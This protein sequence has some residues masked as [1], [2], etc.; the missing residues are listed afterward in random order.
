MTS[1]QSRAVDTVEYNMPAKQGYGNAKMKKL[2]KVQTKKGKKGKKKS[3][4]L[5]YDEELGAVVGRKKHKR[6]EEGPTDEP[7]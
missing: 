1:A 2:T 7:W 3:V 4:E 6:G 5:E